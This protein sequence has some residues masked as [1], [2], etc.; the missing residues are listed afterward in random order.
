M[1]QVAAGVFFLSGNDGVN[2]VAD[3]PDITQRIAVDEGRGGILHRTIGIVKNLT[4]RDNVQDAVRKALEL[5]TPD[6]IIYI[7]GSTF[8][9]SE[10]LPLF[11]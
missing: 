10:A 4:G 3:F 5:A 1:C 8:V 11:K 9:V 7:G 2:R 6:T